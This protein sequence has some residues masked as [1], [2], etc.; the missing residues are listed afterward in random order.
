MDQY[1]NVRIVHGRRGSGDKNQPMTVEME[2]S[3]CGKR[4]W[5]ST[6]VM[7]PKKNWKDG[8]KVVGLAN[9][10][11]L[12]LKIEALESK[13]LTYVRKLMIEQKPFTW[14]GLDTHLQVNKS[15]NTF[16]DFVGDR[17]ANRKDI[18]DG[19]KR[20][21][22]KFWVALK[23]FGKIARFEDLN[24][25]NIHLYDDWLHNRK[26]YTQ[27][28]IASYHKF[29]KIYINEALRMELIERNP[30][31]GIKIEQ[32]KPAQR[33]YLTMEELANIE[34]SDMPTDSLS[35][36]RD[37]FVF[38]C[39]TGLAYSDMAKFS[40][41]K[42]IEKN[43]R[44][45]VHDVRKK[46]GEDFYIVILPKAMEILRKYQF[47]LPIMTNEQ[48]NLRLKLVA[49]YAHVFKN[50]TSHMG[51]HTY[52]T[53]CLNMGT[54][55]EVLAK[56]MGHS[57]IKTTQIYAK[58]VNKTVEEAYGDLEKKLTQAQFSEN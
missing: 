24:K 27:T 25:P 38:Q 2:I 3:F 55:I 34:N 6:G 31:E 11:D 14:Q 41:E 50:L 13:I 46:T 16:I 58:L 49:I 19:T 42:T 10:I 5:I 29:M 7:V 23:E 28:T 9:A 4:K 21:H 36:V 32:G 37:M 39:Y 17:V 54:P 44:Y 40:F 35:K 26:E 43:G 1:P 51:R 53:L 45:V 8:K 48:Y 52:A 57:D 22:K 33:K 12:N 56:M 47:K 15:K 20:N 18:S 30:Y